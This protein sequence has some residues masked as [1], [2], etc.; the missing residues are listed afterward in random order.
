MSAR[1]ELHKLHKETRDHLRILKNEPE[2]ED[3]DE[4]TEVTRPTLTS[5]GLLEVKHGDTAV[6]V[7]PSWQVI[8]LVSILVVGGVVAYVFGGKP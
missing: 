5:D 4:V 7:L 1:R 8:L 6:R 2:L 3:E